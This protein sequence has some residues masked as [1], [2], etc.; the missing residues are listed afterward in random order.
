MGTLA[1]GVFNAITKR[2][3]IAVV[4]AFTAL[5]SALVWLYSKNE[6]VNKSGQ[7]AAVGGPVKTDLSA[8]AVAEASKDS[9]GDGLKDWEEALWR[10][11]ANNPDTDG[12]STTD[13][14][15]IA[16]G[17]DPL[18][19]GPKDKLPQ[20]ADD[21]STALDEVNKDN[22]TYNLVKNL[23]SSGVLNSID[24]NGE[25]TS[26]DFIK[27]FALPKG[28]DVETVLE[29]AAK[30]TAK[31]I[32]VSRENSPE[33]VR[34]YFNSIYEIYA[35]RIIPF[36]KRGDLA[37]L[38]D[39]LQSEDYSKLKDLDPIIEALGQMAKEIKSIPAPADYRSFAVQEVNYILKTKRAVEIF[40]GAEADP[41]AAAVTVNPRVQVLQDM[42]NLHKKTKEKLD[43]Q[44]VVFNVADGGYA[45]FR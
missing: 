23:L 20:P 42:G 18:K 33:A 13:G 3:T 22:L 36:R 5:A 19:K 39:V 34:R 26:S 2:K 37:I 1:H 43:G 25:L 32:G 6:P 15:E 7:L 24:Q 45:F 30:I 44:K 21:S 29:S 31:D 41:L 11:D 9:D 28:L 16:A 17:R 35:R 10:T 8:K 27:N 14:A 40:R 12:D 38:A 4:L